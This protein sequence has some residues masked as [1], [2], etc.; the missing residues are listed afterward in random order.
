MIFCKERGGFLK[1]FS[2]N[3]KKDTK[4][5]GAKGNT[6]AEKVKS[7]QDEKEDTKPAEN[8]GSSK[9][10]PYLTNTILAYTI[11]VSDEYLEWIV[12]EIKDIDDPVIVSESVYDHNDLTRTIEKI[13]QGFAVSNVP[14][15]YLEDTGDSVSVMSKNNKIEVKIL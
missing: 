12:S 2:K 5:K 7:S 9:L 15:D 8:I 11:P 3:K 10:V 1:L 14:D 13:I 4:K 6:D